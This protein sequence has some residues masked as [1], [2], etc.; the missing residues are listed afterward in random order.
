VSTAVG[1][2]EISTDPARLDLEMIHGYLSQRSYWAAGR[3]RELVA[4]SIAN[5]LTFG[6]YE[7]GRQV[8]FAR[9]VTDRATFAYLC[10]VFVLESE[11]SRGIGK[12][13]MEA[14]LAHPDL[15][16]LRRFHLVTLDAHELYRRFGFS[17]LSQPERHMER[18]NLA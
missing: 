4:R 12:R 3:A 10:D 1:E 11:R 6:A 18:V 14:V 8:A 16:G 17:P 13:L 15:Q 2:L 5:S 9:V 7:G